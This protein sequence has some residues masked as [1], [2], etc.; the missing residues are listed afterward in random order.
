MSVIYELNPR[1][2]DKFGLAA[3][4]SGAPIQKVFTRP[5][6]N[7]GNNDEVICYRCGANHKA[8]MGKYKKCKCRYCGREGHLEK[9][10]F[11]K[12]SEG[13]TS[14]YSKKG[15]GR[16]TQAMEVIST[17]PEY[18][19]N[20]IG[21]IMNKEAYKITVVLDEVSHTME[22]D[23]GSACSI[24]GQDTFKQLWTKDKPKLHPCDHIFRTWTKQ[25]LNVI[26]VADVRVTLRERRATLPLV[27]TEGDGVSLLGRNWFNALGIDLMGVAK[28]IEA[29]DFVVPSPGEV[30]LT[31]TATGDPLNTAEISAL[32]K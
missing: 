7:N 10:C 3:Y 5:K 17:G 14:S 32:T 27:I 12:K 13:E 22:V 6:S 9:V 21:S 1:P 4:S 29:D 18:V 23:S 30:M 25:T 2:S 28:P 11:K 31:S 24:M 15:E 8:D 19:I 16:K 26:G 20:K